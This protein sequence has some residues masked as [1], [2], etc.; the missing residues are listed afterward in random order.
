M[1]RVFLDANILFSAAYRKDSG[2]KQIWKLSEVQLLTSAYAIEEARR[3]LGDRYQRGRLTRLL[4]MVRLVP[5]AVEHELPKGI[6]LP[7]K[8][9]PIFLAALLAGATHLITGDVRHFGRYYR[10]TI[11]GVLI[12]TP[13]DY[14]AA[15]KDRQTKGKKQRL[16]SSEER[17]SP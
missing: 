2:L 1:D 15:K 14:L 13:A 8:D 16:G 6:Q 4:R 7:E 9:R 12:M 17:R 11:G 10:Q 5:E 3:N